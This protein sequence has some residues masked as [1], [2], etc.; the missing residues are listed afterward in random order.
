MKSVQ[1]AFVKNTAES[2]LGEGENTKKPVKS[3]GGNLFNFD[4]SLLRREPLHKWSVSETSSQ[5][6]EANDLTSQ[7]WGVGEDVKKTSGFE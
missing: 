6:S 7:A 5:E 1:A 3:T 2:F 4:T